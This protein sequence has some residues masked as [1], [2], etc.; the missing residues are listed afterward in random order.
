MNVKKYFL[1]LFK[2]LFLI[3]LYIYNFYL[4]D[5]LDLDIFGKYRIIFYRTKC[6]GS[7]FAGYYL[8]D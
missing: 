6:H 1:Q 2:L 7:V 5:I 8:S 4:P 3:H